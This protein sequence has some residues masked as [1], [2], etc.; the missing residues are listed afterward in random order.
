MYDIWIQRELEIG[1]TGEKG[2]TR[3]IIEPKCCICC[4]CHSLLA[5]ANGYLEA[6]DSPLLAANA[7]RML[8]YNGALPLLLLTVRRRS[9]YLLHLSYPRC[10]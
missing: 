6:D 3:T 5:A 8:L 1:M 7:I 2:K 10:I 4:L 9:F